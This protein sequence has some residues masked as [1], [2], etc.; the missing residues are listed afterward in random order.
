MADSDSDIEM[1]GGDVDP[2]LQ[3]TIQDFVEKNGLRLFLTWVDHFVNV[4]TNPNGN[5]GFEAMAKAAMMNEELL[6]R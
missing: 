6:A 2:T 1:L 5:C 4:P 3:Q